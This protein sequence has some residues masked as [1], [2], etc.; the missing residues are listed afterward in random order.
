MY[1]LKHRQKRFHDSHI[2]T[3]E[4]KLGNL[5]LVYTLKQFQSKFSK[6]GRGPFVIS[7]VSSSNA[8]KLSTLD[9]EE[10][11]NWINGYRVK[12]YYTLL[13]IEELE[14]LHK[15]KWRQEKHRLV[16]K[17]AKEE[18]REQARKCRNGGVVPFD[19]GVTNCQKFKAIKENVDQD[20]EE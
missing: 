12:K 13:N 1:A 4:F 10:M 9:G 14:C 3:K 18:A 20:L 7:G 17:R 8:V 16:A 15:A 6:A 11:P 2:I 5:V 19:Q